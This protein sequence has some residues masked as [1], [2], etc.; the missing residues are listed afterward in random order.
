M[1]LYKSIVHLNLKGV[2]RNPW[3]PP[4]LRPWTVNED[5]IEFFDLSS[6]DDDAMQEV[7]SYVLYFLFVILKCK[8][9]VC[10]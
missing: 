5:E 4:S 6:S 3:K 7:R 10:K 1:I 2:S 8:F 9:R